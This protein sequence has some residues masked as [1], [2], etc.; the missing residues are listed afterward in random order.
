MMHDALERYGI[1]CAI[2]AAIFIGV[3]AGYVMQA[4]GFGQLP[5]TG[6]QSS[7]RNDA[8]P[9]D[10]VIGPGHIAFSALA[11]K[12]N[13][14]VKSPFRLDKDGNLIVNQ[15]TEN[16]LDGLLATLPSEPTKSDMQRVEAAARIG[17]PDL[18]AH[19]AVTLLRDYIYYRNALSALP[20]QPEPDAPAEER[21]AFDGKVAYLRSRHFDTPTSEALFSV[22]EAQRIYSAEVLRVAA[23][24]KLSDAEKQQ[25]IKT[26]HESLSPKIAAL[27]FNSTEFSAEIEVQ[28]ATVRLRHG[29]DEDVRN[30]R[31]QYFGIEMPT[32]DG[33]STEK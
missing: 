7:A 18:A 25:Q 31:H 10:F 16:A 12:T 8:T 30:L 9:Y 19:K 17:L 33:T 13:T 24:D 15:S 6:L 14:G 3:G 26:L 21:D 28:V 23:N 32:S 22:R 29:S 1:I 4:S 27:E 2:L 5:D 20:G 11:Q